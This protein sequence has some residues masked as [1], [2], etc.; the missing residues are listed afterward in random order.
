M[1]AAS[2]QSPV[3]PEDTNVTFRGT[4]LGLEVHIERFDSVEQVTGELRK[5]FG[6]APSFFRGED[7]VL[8]FS[9]V[10]ILGSFGPIEQVVRDFG[11]RIVAVRSDVEGS[12]KNR[13]PELELER[14]AE[15]PRSNL[16]GLAEIATRAAAAAAQAMQAVLAAPSQATTE[17]EPR[18]TEMII[19]PVRSGCVLEFGGDVTIIGDVNP[20]AEVLAGGNIVVLGSLRGM[21]HAGCLADTGFIWA[22]NL[23]PQQ[24]R[25]GRLVA[26]A[27]DSDTPFGSAEIAYANGE[28][29][30]V[31]E[32]K[33]KLPRGMAPIAR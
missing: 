10:P 31:E 13:Q 9:G 21:A 29:I 26:R 15:P 1:T 14:E 8:R 23:Q 6:K 33:G 12:N 22:I 11:L 16:E 30:I 25:I 27:A 28:Q 19:G 24:L 3:T 17:P 2:A 4:K 7:V 20:G 5:H 32:Y 18:A